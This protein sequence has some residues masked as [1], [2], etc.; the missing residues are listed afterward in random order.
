MGILRTFLL[1][2]IHSS[3][4]VLTLFALAS[5]VFAAGSD[6]DR[7]N[8]LS[9][10]SL[11]GDG[12]GVIIGI[13][14]SGVDDTHPA[15][16]GTVSSGLS[17]MVAEANFVTSEPG[18]TGDD[19]YGHGTAVAGVIMSRDSTFYSVATDARYINARVLDSTNS[20]SSDA[21]VVNGVGFALSNGANVLNM[22]LGY[23]NSNTS[24][25]S[26]LSL[27]TD[28][29]V[30]QLHIPIIISAG[31]AGN[32]AN[33]LPQGPGD[34]YNVIS[35]ASTQSPSYNRVVSS[36]S[37]GP[38]TDGRV[39]PDLAAPGNTVTTAN[40]NWET[41]ADFT[42]WGG[43]S[44]AAPNITA[45]MA[46]QIEYGTT[47]G[48]SIDPLVLKATLMNSADKVNNRNDTAW[49]QASVSIGGGVRTVTS[50]L[51]TSA[52][53]G[54]VNGLKLAQQ[55]TAGRFG[56]G[57][58]PAVGWDLNTV[59]DLSSIE[60]HLGQLEAGSTFTATLTWNRQVG[61]NDDGNGILDS[62]DS[63]SLLSA[64]DNLD[65]TLRLN[66]TTIAQSISL[67]DNVEHLYL[68]GLASGDYSLFVSRLSGGGTGETFGLA[69]AG[70]AVPEP[71]TAT[72]AATGFTF[73]LTRR[74]RKVLKH[75][76][77]QRRQSAV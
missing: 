69:W 19:V 56:E 58:V 39:K 5:S 15:L 67:V 45:I 51:D 44:F 55:Y 25:N 12:T 6:V 2:T 7:I 49:T 59:S 53:A 1:S 72:L 74:P 65:L 18:N 27:M 32:D 20:F 75:S 64:F 52:G 31:N 9:A 47:H 48:L 73:L 23:F 35:A 60:Y 33:H 14:D 76:R 34:A 30:S 3:I 46:A 22:S 66:G 40:S 54:Q 63:F 10:K 16:T 71:G 28:Y 41:Q 77:R 17:R 29:I 4:R 26:K 11:L 21:W 57:N 70:V 50:P 62:N 61:W 42:S 13:I 24:G 68:T 8:G 38:T 36:S 43:T 37:Y